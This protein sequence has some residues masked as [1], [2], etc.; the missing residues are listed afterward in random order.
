MFEQI[1]LNLPQ[2]YLQYYDNA[3]EDS[4]NVAGG[5]RNVAVSNT[6]LVLYQ[7]LL[8]FTVDAHVKTEA[9]G[10]A[11]DITLISSQ[12]AV[13]SLL[14]RILDDA[15]AP[16]KLVL[17]VYRP[18]CVPLPVGYRKFYVTAAGVAY[19]IVGRPIPKRRTR[20]GKKK[21]ASQL[22][23]DV[24]NKESAS[25]GSKHQV[26]VQQLSSRPALGTTNAHC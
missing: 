17:A 13:G 15:T 26:K 2:T 12:P 8:R 7:P 24:E 9:V 19:E 18:L 14:S 5:F 6:A 11:D 4:Q 16:R 23:A 20:R 22:D 10:I 1:F 3:A 25:D 21:K